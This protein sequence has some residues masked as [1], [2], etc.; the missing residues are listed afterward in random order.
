MCNGAPEAPKPQPLPKQPEVL[1]RP[2]KAASEVKDD[3][4]QKAIK[5]AGLSETNKTMGMLVAT[6]YNKK[7]KLGQ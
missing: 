2:V 3:N 1:K 6:G 4:R 7:T 5:A